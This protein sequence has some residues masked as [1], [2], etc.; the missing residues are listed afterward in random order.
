MS[1]HAAVLST[2]DDRRSA[3]LLLQ[4]HGRPTLKSPGHFK[5]DFAT[6]ESMKRCRQMLSGPSQQWAAPRFSAKKTHEMPSDP[7][8]SQPIAR[9][10]PK[11]FAT[12]LAC[13][14]PQGVGGSG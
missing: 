11:R 10:A 12:T 5:A 14:R 1:R 9:V 13:S 2:A 4:G 8:T 6:R 3:Y 7:L